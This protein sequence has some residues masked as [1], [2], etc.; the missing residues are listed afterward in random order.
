MQVSSPTELSHHSVWHVR[1]GD[2]R[3]N[4]TLLGGHD[5]LQLHHLLQLQL[6]LEEL[7][8]HTSESG[9]RR[10]RGSVMRNGLQNRQ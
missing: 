5:L 7:W 6:L 3:K 9:R 10:R 2:T 1:I 8:S 4:L